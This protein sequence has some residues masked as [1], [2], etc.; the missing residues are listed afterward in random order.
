ME[1]TIGARKWDRELKVLNT[2]SFLWAENEIANNF[3]KSPRVMEIITYYRRFGEYDGIFVGTEFYFYTCQNMVGFFLSKDIIQ[4]PSGTVLP[5]CDH[6]LTLSV[7]IW[8]FV[9]KVH[10]VKFHHRIY[11]N[12]KD[13]CNA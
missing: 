6:M 4:W 8:D 13:I 7:S 12:F 2:E 10:W 1:K 5:G 9:T 11:E 3:A